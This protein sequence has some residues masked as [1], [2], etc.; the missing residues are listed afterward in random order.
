M[1]GEG[2]RT[3][4]DTNVLIYLLLHEGRKADTLEPF[5]AAGG[6]ISVQVLNEITNVGRKKHSIALSAIMSFLAELRVILD[7]VP[8][9]TEIH[10]LGLR[11][12][13]R[14]KISTYDA[15]IVAAALE[16]GCD[17]LLSEDMQ[18]G[19]VVDGRLTIVNPFRDE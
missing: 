1:P 17:V 7:V 10:E 14:Y 8:V 4:Y 12:I 2:A 5:L 18:H 9:T 11:L 6:T 3:F 19:M 15:M 13:E 16:C